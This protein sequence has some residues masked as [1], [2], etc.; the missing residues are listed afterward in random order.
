MLHINACSCANVLID[1]REVPSGATLPSD[2]FHVEGF[3]LA[4]QKS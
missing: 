4:V 3:R 2:V 1:V